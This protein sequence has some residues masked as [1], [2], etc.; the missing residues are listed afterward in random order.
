MITTRRALSLGE[1][2]DWVQAQRRCP[3]CKEEQC[4]CWQ[5]LAAAQVEPNPINSALLEML[6]AVSDALQTPYGYDPD[7]RQ[8]LVFTDER[9]MQIKRA[10]AQA[11]AEKGAG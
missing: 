11:A 6:K 2:M 10:I 3:I 9:V 7:R 1:L 8:S 5:A 4:D